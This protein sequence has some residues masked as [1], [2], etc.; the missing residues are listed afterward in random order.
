MTY[1]VSGRARRDLIE[2]WRYIANDSESAADR[3][4]DLIMQRFQLVGE[5]PYAGEVGTSFAPVIAAS[6]QGSV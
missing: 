3:F 6:P 5:N 2:I 4:I 1:R